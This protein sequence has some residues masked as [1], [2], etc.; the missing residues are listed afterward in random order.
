MDSLSV[1]LTAKRS[2][3]T[4]KKHKR[5]DTREE[6]VMQGLAI[7]EGYDAFKQEA[8]TQVQTG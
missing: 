5:V 8:S 6:I 1:I 7:L 3:K 4:E 2:V